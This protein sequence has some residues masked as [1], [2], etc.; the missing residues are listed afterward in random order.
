M[1]SGLPP[2]LR[3]EKINQSLIRCPSK[4]RKPLK[5][6]LFLLHFFKHQPIGECREK[7][8]HPNRQLS[9]PCQNKKR[10]SFFNGFINVSRALFG[11]HHFV[12]VARRF[13]LGASVFGERVLA[14]VGGCVSGTSREHVYPFLTQLGAQGFQKSV[15]GKLRGG[16]PRAPR[17]SAKSGRRRNADNASFILYEFRQA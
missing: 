2:L 4:N 7:A 10:L 6:L 8:I 17:Q 16:I 15:E 11:A 13:R 14:N 3:K 1:F 9:F 5:L 12:F